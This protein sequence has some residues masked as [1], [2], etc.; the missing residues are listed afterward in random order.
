M[1]CM[2]PVNVTVLLSL[3]AAIGV[4]CSPI[5][6]H[7]EIPDH[8]RVMEED[9]A[10]E[11]HPDATPTASDAGQVEQ[12]DAGMSHPMIDGIKNGEPHLVEFR[13][14]LGTLKAG[15]RYVVQFDP[16]SQATTAGEL[17]LPGSQRSYPNPQLPQSNQLVIWGAALSLGVIE[18]TLCL[19]HRSACVAEVV[20][21]FS[22]PEVATGKRLIELAGRH[23]IA[24]IEAALRA[25]VSRGCPQ[26]ASLETPHLKVRALGDLLYFSSPLLPFVTDPALLGELRSSFDRAASELKN[27]HDGD[28]NTSYTQC[29][30]AAELQTSFQAARGLFELYRV[31]GETDHARAVTDYWNAARV[32][33]GY[34]ETLESFVLAGG[35]VAP[36]AFAQYVHMASMAEQLGVA[37]FS[38]SFAPLGVERVLRQQTTTLAERSCTDDARSYA[39]GY[40]GWF[41]AIGDCPQYM[42]YHSF[43]VEAFVELDTVLAA[44]GLCAREEWTFACRNTRWNMLAATA[45]TADL[46]QPSGIIYD[47]FPGSVGTAPQRYGTGPGSRLYYRILSSYHGRISESRGFGSGEIYTFESIRRLATRSVEG[48]LEQG[49]PLHYVVPQY[50]QYRAVAMGTATP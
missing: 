3:I 17:G 20:G 10:I 37:S 15:A 44:N 34:V 23:A 36:N 1:W 29:Y 19:I 46:Q 42:G 31:T 6:G 2:T 8:E 13:T 39:Q 33:G 4:G 27:L 35:N 28:T 38:P 32:P 50:L 45:W 7:Q 16:H 18:G 12:R 14:D 47:R 21:D 5:P 30:G 22:L 40:G 48:Q 49:L 24:A 43:I 9:G 26:D 25:R 41:H 11:S